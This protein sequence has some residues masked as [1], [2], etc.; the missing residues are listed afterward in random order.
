VLPLL[1]W[2]D[3]F[4]YFAAGTSRVA[5]FAEPETGEFIEP[6]ETDWILSRPVVL[7][8]FAFGRKAVRTFRLAK[9]GSLYRLGAVCGQNRYEQGRRPEVNNEWSFC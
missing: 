7:S 1:R 5:A 6:M 2:S 9:T 4:I 8:H 3:S